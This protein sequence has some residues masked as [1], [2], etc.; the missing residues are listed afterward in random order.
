[1]PEI[2]A[3]LVERLV[4]AQFP[5]WAHL[6]VRPVAAGGW[7]NR[8]FHLGDEMSVRLPS[9]ERYVAQ[10]KK[11]HRFLP[12][13]GARLPLPVPAPVGLG[14]PG[15]GYPWPWSVYRWIEGETAKRERIVDMVRFAGDLA[16]FLLALWGIEAS[17][18]P[19]AGM[20]NFHRGGS[21]A[22][23]DDEARRSIGILAD[24]LD[25]PLM[26]EIWERA[27]ASS[28]TEKPVWVH[29]DVAEGNLLVREGRLSAVIDFGS[30]GVG[31]PACDLIIAWTLFDR[32]AAQAFR[33]RVA[34]DPDTWER[35]RGWCLWKALITIA[36]LREKDGRRAD[37]HRRWIGRVVS[38]HLAAAA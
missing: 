35:A 16:D 21:L 13:L 8:T 2:D 14:K 37:L 9:A 28:W 6:P 20:H 26:T 30:S 38:D 12:A 22:V 24:E 23:Y 5:H 10:V 32:P 18:G 1:M 11:E 17:A 34:L 33:E 19:P 3:L 7:D 25:A 15:E 31:D 27:L 4:A 36:D 29:G